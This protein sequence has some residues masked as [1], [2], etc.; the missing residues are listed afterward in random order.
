[1]F[2]RQNLP[3]NTKSL[4][5]VPFSD[6]SK[7]INTKIN[8]NLLPLNYAVNT[9]NFDFCSGALTDGLGFK[10]LELPIYDYT[11]K[12][13]TPDGVSKIIRCWPYIWFNKTIDDYTPLLIAYCDDKMLYYARVEGST[14]HFTSLGVEFENVPMCITYRVDEGDCFFAFSKDKIMKFD[15]A[16]VPTVYTE[17][18]PRIT[19]IALHAGRLFATSAGDE[20]ILY[21]S[22]DL[23]PTNW[24]VSNFEGGY[25]EITGE[26][27]RLKKLVE[28]NNSL[29]IIREFGIS[30]LSGWGMQS[31]M[32]VKNLYLTTGKIYYNS[33]SLY[34]QTIL[35]LCS[36]GV[37][38]MSAGDLHKI[39]LGIDDMLKGVDNTN[40]YGA[41]FNGKYYLACKLNFDDGEI[42]G[43]ES[44]DYINNALLEIDMSNGELNIV[45][46]VDIG[47]M[48]PFLFG[49]I[50]KLIICFNNGETGK[51]SELIHNGLNYGEPTK[52]VWQSPLT[53]LG[54]PNLKKVVKNLYINTK[55]DIEIVV[56]TE[57]GKEYVFYA[58][59]MNEP[60]RVVLNVIAEKISI[61]F[62][63]E[64]NNCEISNPQV[65]IDLI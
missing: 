57:K 39:N 25:I 24:N 16:N 3:S 47:F 10:E 31:A 50:N 54:Y 40:S 63:C 64:N 33:A 61:T 55:T 8:E 45:R 65:D 53:D 12:I 35:M 60:Q 38:Y 51:I 21:F 26:R 2:Y 62:K 17:D 11:K 22:D 13:I 27:G 59:G 1:M 44:G 23:N 14:T 29:Y 42:V 37:Y 7:G 56:V 6:F 41:F 52:K 4:I 5:R 34:G 48:Y 9:Y 30:K 18:I 19:S 36:D 32:N 43:C 49:E 15:G 28:A 20:N 46:G 58:K